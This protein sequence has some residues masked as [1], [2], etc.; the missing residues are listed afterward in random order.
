MHVPWVLY[1]ASLS[2]S[3]QRESLERVEEEGWWGR[4][5]RSPRIKEKTS[6]G[7]VIIQGVGG[8]PSRNVYCFFL[9]LVVIDLQRRRERGM[10]GRD[11]IEM[12][13]RRV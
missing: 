7:I 8:G 4:G 13:I 2:P 1:S 9:F 12:K 3:A 11:G 5:A 6:K 10:E